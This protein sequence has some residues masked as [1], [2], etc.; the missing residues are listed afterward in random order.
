MKKSKASRAIV[1]RK[2]QTRIMKKHDASL[3]QKFIIDDESYKNIQEM[4][5]YFSD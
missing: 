4:N 5:E 2:E 3:H 1:S